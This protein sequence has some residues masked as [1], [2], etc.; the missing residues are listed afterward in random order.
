LQF[1]HGSGEAGV[2]LH[3]DLEAYASS[4]RSGAHPEPRRTVDDVQEE[5][6]LIG[7]ATQP[8]LGGKPGQ[9][10]AAAVA[11]AGRRDRRA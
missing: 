5:I 6:P 2:I 4:R 1:V 9:A 11:A 3:E 8:A 7:R 10:D